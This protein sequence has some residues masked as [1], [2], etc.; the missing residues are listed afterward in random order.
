MLRQRKSRGRKSPGSRWRG[1]LLAVNRGIPC[2][3][4]SSP[5]AAIPDRTSVSGARRQN[6][7][8]PPTC[9]QSLHSASVASCS[10]LLSRLL[11]N[12]SV[13]RVG[14]TSSIST[15]SALHRKARLRRYCARNAHF[16]P[17]IRPAQ[18]AQSLVDAIAFGIGPARHSLCLFLPYLPRR[19]RIPSSR[20][21]S[22][23]RA[24]PVSPVHVPAGEAHPICSPHLRVKFLFSTSRTFSYRKHR[25]LL[26]LVVDMYPAALLSAG[27]SGAL[28]YVPFSFSF[29]SCCASGCA[30]S[31]VA[32]HLID[33]GWGTEVISVNHGN[34]MN[35]CFSLILPSALLLGGKVSVMRERVFPVHPHPGLPYRWNGIGFASKSLMLSTIGPSTR[36]IPSPVP[37]SHITWT[38]PLCRMVR[39]F[40]ERQHR[41]RT[42]FP[43]LPPS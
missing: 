31:S 24:V 6:K 17:W 37:L 38:L 12:L 27:F 35:T 21:F 3:A 18:A 41:K 22:S 10:P 7:F 2:T 13:F 4:G 26:L 39:Q 14:C 23:P 9:L 5:W 32:H 25:F 30:D 34:G 36:L 40:L 15:L 1:V 28:R 42:V 20:I 11:W 33:C 43:S 8:P 29:L 19:L 16:F